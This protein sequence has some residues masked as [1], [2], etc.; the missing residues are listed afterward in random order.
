[1]AQVA[2][3]VAVQLIQLTVAIQSLVLSLQLVEV[4]EHIAHLVLM[5]ALEVQ[6]VALQELELVVL[7]RLIKVLQELMAT[8]LLAQSVVVVELEELE[9]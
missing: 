5:E 6:A 2:V 7:E 1:L 4:E 3:A 8:E 9:A